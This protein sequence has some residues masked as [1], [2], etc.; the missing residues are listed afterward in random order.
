MLK[1]N[2]MKSILKNNILAIFLL[3]TISSCT[4]SETNKTEDCD[5]KINETAQ[6]LL[7]KTEALNK[8]Q[9][10]ANCNSFKTAWLNNYNQMKE[11]GRSTAELDAVRKNEFDNID[12]SVFGGSTGGGGN[13]GG[14]GG[15]S[16]NGNVMFWTKSSTLGAITINFNGQI[17][18]ITQYQSSGSPSG[19]GVPGF[20]NYNLAAGTYSYTASSVSGVQWSGSV[21]VPTNGGC[22]LQELIFSGTG[23]GGGGSTTGNLIVWQK[24]DN[25]GGTATITVNGQKGYISSVYPNAT[26]A[27]PPP[28]GATGCATFYNLAPGNYTVYYSDVLGNST[29][30]A[31]VVAG[32]CSSLGFN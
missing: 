29:G 24:K 10:V 30:Q 27:N 2:L 4:E 18:Q 32:A 20:A 11:C 15:G 9:T 3:L 13:T 1:T 5:A 31:V 12:C 19:C 7:S 28:C 6:V 21:N 17:K 25:G 22:F 14:T 23:G 26:Q 8:N 16:T